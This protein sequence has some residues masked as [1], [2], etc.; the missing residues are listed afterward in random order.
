MAKAAWC[1]VT[2]TSGKENGTINISAAAHTGRTGRTTSVLV[3]AEN[4]TKPSANIAVSQAAAAVSTTMDTT[5]P[6]VPA[7]GGTVVIN[8]TSNS[9]KLSF[10]VKTDV[11]G[12]S[13]PD[14]GTAVV[15]VNNVA[16]TSNT[17]IAGDPGAA[18][19]YSFVATVTLPASRFAKDSVVT[20]ELTD[21]TE[22]K[23]ICQFTWKAGASSLS[24]DKSSLSLVTAGTAQAVN[25]KSNDEW[26]VS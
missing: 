16:I 25:V 17:A 7:A 9:S 10:V 8:G 3:Q 13:V 24:V 23:K 20:F 21:D 22:A 2:P 1:T 12:I 14:L 19:R 5:K 18:A 6:D 11:Y 4:G 26:T 15:K